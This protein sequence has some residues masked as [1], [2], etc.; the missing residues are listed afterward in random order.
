MTRQSTSYRFPFVAVTTL[1]FMWGFITVMVDALIPRLKEVFELEYWQASLVQMAW[2]TAYLLV[3]IPGG[4]LISRI[5]YKKGILLGLGLMALGCALF[6]PAAEIRTYGLFLSALF[7]L[8]SGITVLQVAANPYIS[9]L[10]DSRN[11]SSRLNLAQAFNSL[12]TTIAP[13]LSAAYLLSDKISTK[14]EILALSD[15][16]KAVYYQAEASQVQ[17]PFLIIAGF[18]VVLMLV[19]Y[20][21]KL[22]KIIDET[23]D[24]SFSSFKK[25][26][27]HRPLVLG[28]IAIFVYVG[29][30]VSIGSWLTN[31]FISLD[32]HIII[33]E[34]P[35]L[36][37]IVHFIS[38]TFTGKDPGLLDPK[39][40]VGSFVFFYWG[41]AMLGRF[42]G[43]YLTRIISPGKVLAFFSIGAMA[44]ILL[45][46]SSSGL[47]AMW[48]IIAVGLF[49]SIMFPT[50]FTLAI[51]GLGNLKPQGSGILCTAIFG[52]AIIPFITGMCFDYVGFGLGFSVLVLCYLYIMYFGRYSS[53][54]QSISLQS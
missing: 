5:G 4:I 35:R 40:I 43:S 52:G 47:L 26:L 13:I 32:L 36:E 53:K 28:A 30:E 34:S 15:E 38:K 54:N 10:G 22:P 29:A 51:D 50:I 6:Y 42:I 33:Q 49:N 45:S 39:G 48:S 46:V 18:I 19:F 44:L 21:I 7:I 27:G 9:V 11:S 8:A 41:G 25:A 37:S 3:S 16:A 31:Y 14:E 12:G 1:F 24:Q 23:A 2:F 17:G 20:A